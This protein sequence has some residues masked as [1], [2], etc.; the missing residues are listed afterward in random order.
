M[1]LPVLCVVLHV[2]LR[3]VLHVVLCCMLCCVLCCAALHC[4]LQ[5]RLRA[6]SVAAVKEADESE[7]SKHLSCKTKTTS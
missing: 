2:V 7:E 6:A 1:L 3:A 5:G 4:V